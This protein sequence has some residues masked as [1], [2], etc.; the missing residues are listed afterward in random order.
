MAKT[1]HADRI[2]HNAMLLYKNKFTKQPKVKKRTRDLRK[3]FARLHEDNELNKII[4]PMSMPRCI[5]ADQV[6][7]TV[8]SDEAARILRTSMYR[9]EESARILVENLESAAKKC[10]YKVELAD[11]TKGEAAGLPCFREFL[12]DCMI[13]KITAIKLIRKDR[14]ES[15][16]LLF[17]P[18]IILVQMKDNILEIGYTPESDFTRLFKGVAFR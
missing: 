8:S 3:V 11:I 7:D 5:C 13:P 10:R 18:N 12:K 15:P 2:T 9:A 14:K 17:S 1:K 6:F 4:Y 16:P